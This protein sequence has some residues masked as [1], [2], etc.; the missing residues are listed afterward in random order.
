MKMTLTQSI[1]DSGL[2]CPEGK[3]KIE[4]ADTDGVKGMLIEVRA[5]SMDHTFYLRVRDSKGVTRLLR[6]G[7]TSTTSLA[8]ARQAAKEMKARMTLGHDLY[9]ERQKKATVPLYSE[10]FEKT[11]EPFIALRKRSKK[12]IASTTTCV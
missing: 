6:L 7:H 5:G 1:V 4:I 12:E 9:G 11:Y 2:S 3:R 8:S 10:F